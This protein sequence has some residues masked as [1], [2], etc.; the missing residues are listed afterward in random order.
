[1]ETYFRST[2]EF[3][4]FFGKFP[5]WIYNVEPYKS[6]LSNKANVKEIYM[7]YLDAYTLSQK[8]NW[9]DEN[10]NIYITF[11][12]DRVTKLTG[13][14]ESTI[15]KAKKLLQDLGLLKVKRQNAK[16]VRNAAGK[17][18][19]RINQPNR[20][21]LLRPELP[22]TEFYDATQLSQADVPNNTTPESAPQ[23][24]LNQDKLSQAPSQQCSNGVVKNA[25]K[26]EKN[27]DVSEN[28]KESQLDFSP[29][30]Y[31]Q[32]QINAQNKMLVDT[33]SEYMAYSTSSQ[34]NIFSNRTL[35]TLKWWADKPED[36]NIISSIIIKARNVVRKALIL[37]TANL[38]YA[39]SHGSHKLRELITRKLTIPGHPFSGEDISGNLITDVD[40]RNQFLRSMRE[41]NQKYDSNNPIKSING[42]LCSS[43]KWLF[44]QKITTFLMDN[45]ETMKDNKFLADWCAK[46]NPNPKVTLF[47]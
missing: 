19:S 16:L 46:H 39:F 44:T 21:Y 4:P 36:I 26:L 1:M 38:D 37:D 14:K 3:Q 25:S 7:L 22:A 11:T 32:E 15:T 31:T 24:G 20:L 45:V 23:Q 28:H 5:K 10:G 40:I 41:I 17:V 2:E 30:S 13:I 12:N 6:K 8:N 29:A 27:F 47:I 42:Y 9:H 33:A 18:I 43:F 34:T 35:D